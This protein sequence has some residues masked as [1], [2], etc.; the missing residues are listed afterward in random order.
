MTWNFCTHNPKSIDL[1]S[2]GTGVKLNQQQSIL[3]HEFHLTVAYLASSIGDSLLL[4]SRS[5]SEVIPAMAVRTLVRW[6]FV[7]A[8][9]SLLTIN[10][11][12]GIDAKIMA[13]G[14]SVNSARGHNGAVKPSLIR[15]KRF[16]LAD[17]IQSSSSFKEVLQI[18]GGQAITKKKVTRPHLHFIHILR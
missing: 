7:A 10:N 8:L 16:A 1:P 15:T 18:R 14:E 5:H 11:R 17:S 3:P 12:S 4:P 13:I 2:R 6:S 9:L